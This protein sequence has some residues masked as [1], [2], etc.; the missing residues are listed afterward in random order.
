[1]SNAAGKSVHDVILK[2]RLRFIE[3][4]RPLLWM[5]LSSYVVGAT[6]ALLLFNWRGPSP[7]SWMALGAFV[8]GLLWIITWFLEMDDSHF[9]RR[10]AW[11]E[12][13]TRK[14]LSKKL[15]RGWAWLD[16]IWVGPRNADHVMIG[17]ESVLVVETKW[18]SSPKYPISLCQRDLAGELLACR[19]AAAEISDLL[20]SKGIATK[21]QGILVLWGPGYPDTPFG[22]MRIGGTWVL[23][24]SQSSEWRIE[25]APGKVMEE[26]RTLIASQQQRH[27]VGGAIGRFLRGALVA[28]GAEP[29]EKDLPRRP[30]HGGS[31]RGSK[32]SSAT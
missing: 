26:A 13:W 32:I 22:T 20:T 24:G 25:F 18:K 5:V 31:R 9:R 3:R 2:D 29:P 15:P 8:V 28:L 21:T 27:R 4:N 30:N 11:A 17:P 19:H 10:G 7:F 6:V 12:Q 16:D 23:I 14:A 1:M